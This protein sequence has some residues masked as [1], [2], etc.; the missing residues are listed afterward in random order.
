[1]QE[2]ETKTGGIENREQ[3]YLSSETFLVTELDHDFKAKPKIELLL[4]GEG[5]LPF[6]T[7]VSSET[8]TIG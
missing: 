5:Y 7:D 2:K 1:M 4:G 3:A 8:H 6:Y